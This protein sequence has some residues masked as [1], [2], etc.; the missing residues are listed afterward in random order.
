[1]LTSQ[2]KYGGFPERLIVEGHDH[3]FGGAGGERELEY[4][5]RLGEGDAVADQP[6][7]AL[8]V[9]R[10]F[11]GDLEDLG[12]VALGGDDGRLAAQHRAQVVGLGLW[13]AAT[14]TTSRPTSRPAARC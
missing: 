14:L 11:R 5:V 13:C 3:F 12:E 6:G 10:D 8:L 9:L 4:L 7:E 2:L 1:M